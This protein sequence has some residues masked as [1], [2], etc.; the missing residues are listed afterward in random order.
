M[1][2]KPRPPETAKKKEWH[3]ELTPS[4]ERKEELKKRLGPYQWKPGQ[5]GNPKGAPKGWKPAH[6]QLREALERARFQGKDVIQRFVDGACKNPVLLKA[7]MD[8]L[9]ANKIQIGIGPDD[10]T[11]IM[12][13]VVNV[14]EKHVTSLKVREAIA[15]DLEAIEFDE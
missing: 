12:G 2:R 4:A 11:D 15:T 7:L 9:V 14:I 8:K 6:V 13:Q 1:A 5:S 10:L 3:Q